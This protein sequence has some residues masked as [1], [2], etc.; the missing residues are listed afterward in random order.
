L[1]T[2]QRTVRE[3][4]IL[5]KIPLVKRLYQK[6]PQDEEEVEL[7]VAPDGLKQRRGIRPQL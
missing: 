3:Y 7:K 4:P 2:H 1:E 5:K 6:L